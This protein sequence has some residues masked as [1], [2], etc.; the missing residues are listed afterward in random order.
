M[1][2]FHKYIYKYK[3]MTPKDILYAI[4]NVTTKEKYPDIHLNTGFKPIVRNHNGELIRLETLD[5]NGE[6]H[7]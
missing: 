5:V 4:L 3:N 7:Y 6:I 1:L 2:Q